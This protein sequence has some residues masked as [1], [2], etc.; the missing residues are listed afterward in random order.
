M[1]LLLSTVQNRLK[2]DAAGCRILV[3]LRSRKYSKA[4]FV[5]TYMSVTGPHVCLNVSK[6][7]IYFISKELIQLCIYLQDGRADVVAN[8]AGDRV[9]P[10]IV[11]YS[12]NEEVPFSSF[13][14]I[15]ISIT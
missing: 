14:Y 12:K 2:N 3:L 8:D 7:T 11:A 5:S 9:T 15:E 13:L 1:S 4:V 6:E 10:A